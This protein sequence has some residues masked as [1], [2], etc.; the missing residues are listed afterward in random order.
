[1]RRVAQLRKDLR[2]HIGNKAL[3]DDAEKALEVLDRVRL[4]DGHVA[5]DRVDERLTQERGLILE[6]H[7]EA[8]DVDA[9]AEDAERRAGGD[10]IVIDL[11][12][13]CLHNRAWDR[14]LNRLDFGGVGVE[15]VANRRHIAT[16][17]ARK[18]CARAIHHCG[19]EIKVIVV[20]DAVGRYPDR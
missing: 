8:G 4:A 19:E 6:Q 20:V 7:P 13:K 5:A 14:E 1:L 17:H 16:G 11:D 9:L 15:G 10:W 18:R 12:A 3:H 2:E